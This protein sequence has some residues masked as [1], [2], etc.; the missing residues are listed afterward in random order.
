M[1][2]G[3]KPSQWNVNKKPPILPKNENI[4]NYT[5]III[6]IHILT[7]CDEDNTYL[8]YIGTVIIVIATILIGIYI[9]EASTDIALD[10]IKYNKY[11]ITYK[12]TYKDSVYV[13]TDTIVTFKK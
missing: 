9:H 5:N 3:V 10:K 6:G 12:G 1:I 8:A 11:E 13:V 4:D 2:Q 7:A